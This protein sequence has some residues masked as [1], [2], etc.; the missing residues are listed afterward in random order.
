[1]AFDTSTS[2]QRVELLRQAEK[3][4]NLTRRVTVGSGVLGEAEGGEGAA[5]CT[6]LSSALG[7][8]GYSGVPEGSVVVTSGTGVP[9]LKLDES[10]LFDSAVALVKD[11]TLTGAT[12]PGTTTTLTHAASVAVR[13]SDGTTIVTGA[14]A[15]ATVSANTLNYITLPAGI[16]AAGAGASV[17]GGVVNSA[18]TDS[19][20]AT[21]TVA[22][23]KV[24]NVKLTAATT[25]VVDQSDTVSVQNSAGANGI[26]S[27]VHVANGAVT[28]VR[29]P[30]SSA[31]VSNGA[32]LTVPVT[33]TY[34]TTATIAIANGVI[35][36]ITLS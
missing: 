16:A 2:D 27:V 34:T 9:L 17:P 29:L 20:P 23:G 18:G 1:M 11:G 3:T 8:I 10:L 24:T 13:E 12:L 21:F 30:A 22:G 28:A 5:L 7:A 4:A 25:A 26:G 32:A 19:H 31:A 15:T 35:T 33:G 14:G 6:A 36:G